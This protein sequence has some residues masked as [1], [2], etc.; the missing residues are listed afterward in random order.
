M[1]AFFA[2]CA[3][4]GTTIIISE[5]LADTNTLGILWIIV[6]CLLYVILHEVLHLLLGNGL[7]VACR[8][9][10][11]NAGEQGTELLEYLGYVELR[12]PHVLVYSE[13]NNIKLIR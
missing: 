9:R 6:S 13:W 8:N 2:L 4:I 11:A 12:Y 5:D 10:L 1:A 3:I 7:A